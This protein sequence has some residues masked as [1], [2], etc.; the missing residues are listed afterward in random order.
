MYPNHTTNEIPYG[1]CQ[2]GCGQ[3]APVA[4]VTSRTYGWVKGEPK[5]Y[6]LGH[7]LK[8]RG[9]PTLAARF[10][11]HTDKRG[12]NECW[13]YRKNDGGVVKRYGTVSFGGKS[14]SA[15]RVSYELHFGTV[16]DDMLVC[17]TCD[18][19]ACVNPA[20]LFLGTPLD[21][22]QDKVAKGRMIGNFTGGYD[23]RR[24]PRP[25]R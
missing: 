13:L 23:P 16:P 11:Q 22:M 20:H 15:H 21:N 3:L 10:W 5:R 12:P 19:P 25:K 6:V 1:Y 4:T 2:C 24:T 7:T 9:K 18:N 17:H 14:Y 8:A